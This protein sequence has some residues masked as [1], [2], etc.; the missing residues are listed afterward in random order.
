MDQFEAA[1]ESYK[2]RQTTVDQ[3]N[4]PSGKEEIIAVRRNEED[5]IIAVKTNTGRE[6]DYPTA[7]SEAKSGKLSHV[8]VF[9]KY[10][11]DILRSEPD[12]IKGNNLSELPDF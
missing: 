11:R 5:N 9:H 12:G 6:L 1:Y 8:D 3:E 7:L 2:A 10:G 4:V